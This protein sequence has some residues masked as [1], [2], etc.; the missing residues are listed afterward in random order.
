MVNDQP[1]SR[2]RLR[3]YLGAAPG[4]G[5]TFAMLDEGR[6][7]AGRG[8]D[9]V[10]GIVETHDR[11]NTAALLADLEVLPRRVVG[12]RGTTLDEL[13]V[14]TVLDR[15]PD[16]VLVDELAH[17]NAPGS[18]NHKRWQDIDELLDAGID[19]VSTVNI[20]HLESVND[21]VERITGVRQRETVPD[22]W[23]RAA[24]QVQL[25]DMTPEA[26]RRRMAH[27]NV[28]P[29]DRIDAALA[30]YFRPG[31]LGALREL[32][33]LWVADRVEDEL[34]AYLESHGIP[35]AWETR[36][37]VLIAVTGAPGSDAVIRRAARLSRRL[38][39][40]LVG[41]H[42]TATDGL[43]EGR[44]PELEAHRRLLEELGGNYREVVGDDIAETL[45]SVAR[46]ERITQIVIGASR[47][48]RAQE[49]T[50]GSVV[51][52]LLRLARDLDVHVISSSSAPADGAAVAPPTGA[53]LRTP[54]P[55]RRRIAAWVL[56]AVG[57]PLLMLALMPFSD[58]IGVPTAMLIALTFVVSVATLGGVLP[59][60]AAAVVCSLALNFFLV[61][62]TG[63][64]T[65]TEPENAL[66]LVV[67]IVVGATVATL[68]DRVARR[69]AEA[70]RARSDADA[71]TRTA[72]VVAAEP[73]PLPLLMAEMR[74]SLGLEAVALLRV[75]DGGS[76]KVV[77]SSGEDPPTR[78]SDGMLHTVTDDGRFVIVW[79]GSAL[80]ADAVDLLETLVGQVGVAVDSE[81]LR[82]EAAAAEVL[83]RADELRTGI[84][85][86]V[87]HDLRTPLA[88]IKA[89]VTSLLSPDMTFGP[90]DTREFLTL[91][92]TEVDRLDRVVGNLLD[93]SRLQSGGL[94]V[95]RQPT[96]V[97]DVV[98][99]AVAGVDGGEVQRVEV[100]LDR[101]L[102]LV[103]IDG[104]LAERAVANVVANAL[105]V[106]PAD[107]P[108]VIDAA[109]VGDEVHLRVI[110]R[111][112][113][114]RAGD[115]DR[116]LAPFQ[117]LG[118]RSNQA[119]VGL[120]LAI[121]NGFTSAVG[122][123]MELEDTPGGGLTVV[124]ELPVAVVEA[125]TG[126]SPP[127]GEPQGEVPLGEPTVRA[128][129]SRP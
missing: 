26:L 30:N 58:S 3:V 35:G 96:A 8:T 12:Y 31:N 38:Q 123:R 16:V 97:E 91:I 15:R 36:E 65:V 82:R 83:S 34:Q 107:V 126:E 60:V 120:G 109:P 27:G 67:F 46:S 100:H 77:A 84:L 43:S 116:V 9:V 5:K 53:G 117:R 125:P 47:R 104:P 55:R 92:D 18:R 10:V 78:P 111:G 99:A 54:L 44:G 102:P 103:E 108:V 28:Y 45:V 113:G 74:G 87:S 115:R 89:S 24:E 72:A 56:L 129:R 80:D 59:G 48:T 2:G 39:G 71:L 69:S 41:V 21:V 105:A 29:A 51:N 22:S 118:D 52:D 64:L 95:L 62:P 119:G 98:A 68:V 13:D 23:V 93:M 61:P 122:G 75:E 19:V 110:D 1:V 4:V 70:V 124:F 85:Q 40:E 14:D 73:D 7:R 42:I 20:Q 101:N 114:I 128:D 63:T 6:R 37:R 90:D 32:A 49:L 112:P 106:Q 94:R 81:R 88:G 79:R 127:V 25:I 50:R 121:A 76:W 11:P 57:A 33:L 17:T 66:A 86:A